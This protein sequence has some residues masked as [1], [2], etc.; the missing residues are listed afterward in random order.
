MGRHLAA[1]FYADDGMVALSELEWLQ[2]SFNT[3]VGLFDQVGL[4]TNIG[5]TVGIVCHPCQ[6]AGNLPKAMDGRRFTEEGPTY[7]EQLKG[8]V[9][10]GACSKLLESGSLSSLM[11]TQH[12]RVVKIR[13]KWITPAAGT[14]PQTFRMTF[15][16]KGGP[17]NCPVAGCPGRVATRTAMQ[18]QFLHRHALDTMVILEEGNFPP[19]RCAQCNML[20]PRQDLNRR[21]PTKTKCARGVERKR[22]WI[23]EAYARGS[24]ERAFE[25]Y[26]KPINNVLAFRYLGRVLTAVDDDWIAVFGNFSK[27]RKSWVQLSLVLGQEGAELKVSGYFIRRYPRWCYSLERRCGSS[28]R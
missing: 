18:V 3:L 8:Q 1:I 25:A 15:P 9:E 7:T 19:L 11:M 12:G 13:Q 24:L 26:G 27:G 10:C 4:C 21:Q 22:Q 5:K 2:V 16:A 20:V 28:L 14:G 6:A 17:R 23:A